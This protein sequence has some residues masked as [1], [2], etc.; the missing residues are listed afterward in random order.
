MFNYVH[1]MMRYLLSDSLL[2]D[3]LFLYVQVKRLMLMSRPARQ[4]P[5]VKGFPNYLISV[6]TLVIGFKFSCHE[7][8]SISVQRQFMIFLDYYYSIK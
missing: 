6:L 3:F 2:Y 1:Y 7:T 5:C 8:L 4:R